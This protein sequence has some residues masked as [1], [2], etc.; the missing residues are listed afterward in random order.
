MG[1]SGIV[2]IPHVPDLYN[3]VYNNSRLQRPESTVW[4]FSTFP[5]IQVLMTVTFL[6]IFPDAGD[7]KKVI[8]RAMLPVLMTCYFTICQFLRLLAALHHY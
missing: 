6:S 2:L 8:V 5:I 3:E 7:D 1:A 4:F